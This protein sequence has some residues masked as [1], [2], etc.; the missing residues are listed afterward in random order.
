MCRFKRRGLLM[1]N[2][3]CVLV[4]AAT[5]TVAFGQTPVSSTGWLINGGSLIDP[6]TLRSDFAAALQ[7]LGSRMTT[8]S[9]ATTVVVGSVTDENGTRPAKITVQA[10]GY[11]RYEEPGT[12]RV[13][14][15]NGSSFQ[16]AAGQ[17][18]LDDTRVIESLLAEFPDDIFLQLATGGNL[19]RV[20]GHFRTDNGKTP[21]YSGPYWTL[22]AYY[23]PARAGLASGQALQQSL[24][25]AIDEQAW[26]L[27]EIR[28]M[29]QSTASAKVV[30][31]QFNNWSQQ[32]G[33]WYPGQIVRLENGQQVLSFQT[34]TGSTGAASPTSIFQ[35]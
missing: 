24:F 25:V 9:N 27:S 19:R 3:I 4:A 31:T 11:L 30:E 29:N 15:F 16:S 14:T 35:P 12:L 21:N 8:T 10:P 17:L 23:P 1:T 28:V 18:T 2:R 26:L 13:L 5:L 20:G 33:Q 6:S 34:D 32:A 7:K 22:Y